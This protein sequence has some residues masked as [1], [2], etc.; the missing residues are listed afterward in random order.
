MNLTLSS[1]KFIQVGII[2]LGTL[3]HEISRVFIS[4]AKNN[5]L[6]I[7]GIYCENHAKQTNNIL[8]GN[9]DFECLLCL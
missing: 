9:L 6:M 4:P 8:M 7:L 5:R 2:H 1:V 3:A